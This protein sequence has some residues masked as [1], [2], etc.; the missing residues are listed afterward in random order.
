[1]KNNKIT[2]DLTSYEAVSNLH[3]LPHNGDKQAEDS[4]IASIINNSKD[5]KFKHPSLI[6]IHF[7]NPI[8]RLMY[9]AFIELED[10]KRE[11]NEITIMEKT[12]INKDFIVDFR[13]NQILIASFDTLCLRVIDS[14][15][16]HEIKKIMADPKFDITIDRSRLDII[17]EA[18]AQAKKDSVKTTVRT[19]CDM[20]DEL[21]DQTFVKTNFNQI[22][23]KVGGFP[24]N[25]LVVIAGR[26][27]MGKT[28]FMSS[29]C[30]ANSLTMKTCFITMEMKDT[31]IGNK[32]IKMP[33]KKNITNIQ[34]VYLKDHDIDTLIED[35]TN[36]SKNGTK[37]FY[38]DYIQLLTTKNSKFNEVQ[39]IKLICM[40]LKQLANKL[41]I[42]I[43]TASQFN[44]AYALREDKTPEK[45]DLAGS[46]E[47]EN[48]SDLVIL[49]HSEDNN[50]KRDRKEGRKMILIIAK[51]RH[52]VEGTIS[53]LRMYE[54]QEF[55]EET[56]E[57]IN[58]SL[59]LAKTI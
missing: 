21:N 11:I 40:S 48:S 2:I 58:N 20:L 13:L 59:K 57:E 52:G 55:R 37:I 23:L 22:D 38:I 24:D 50:N 35:I 51:N 25:G 42:I 10:E 45:S 5:I 15:Y 7:F 46:S 4:L 43:V 39:S 9:E 8:N 56:A 31:V 29:L 6:E 17:Y 41:D 32:I 36:I 53:T 27:G 3:K 34:I 12:K 47:I 49:I 16:T 28:S 1:M 19:L 30:C 54:T 33:I 26:S 44:R 14:Y 18:I